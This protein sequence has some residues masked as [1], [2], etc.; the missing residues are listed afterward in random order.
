MC[1][2]TCTNV[3]DIAGAIK[4]AASLD[5]STDKAQDGSDGRFLKVRDV[6]ALQPNVISFK[7]CRLR[8]WMLI[9]ITV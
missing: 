2:C 7:S 6:G 5:I 9:F 1:Q 4:N 8:L 3:T